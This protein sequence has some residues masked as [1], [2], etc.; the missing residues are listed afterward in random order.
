VRKRKFGV[1]ILVAALVASAM[2]LMSMAQND[3][4]LPWQESVGTQ[5]SPFSGT[6]DNR[7]CR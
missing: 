7:V 1:A 4:C 6:K 2:L 5:G 3:G